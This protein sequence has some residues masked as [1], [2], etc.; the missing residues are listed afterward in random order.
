MRV[1]VCTDAAFAVGDTGE[2][3]VEGAERGGGRGQGGSCARPGKVREQLC[4]PNSGWKRPLS[5]GLHSFEPV[6]SAYLHQHQH[7]HQHEQH[8]CVCAVG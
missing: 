3:L 2:D 7:Q 5:H 1:V 8:K 6:T 4:P